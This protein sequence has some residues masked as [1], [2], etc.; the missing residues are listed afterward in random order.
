MSCVGIRVTGR[1]LTLDSWL[2]ESGIP[3][4]EGL[5][6]RMLTKKIR[7]KGTMLGILQVYEDLGEDHHALQVRAD[8]LI[9]EVNRAIHPDNER[10]AYVVAT[11][12][13]ITFNANSDKDVVLIDCG[14]KRSIIK[15]ILQRKFNVV[16]VPPKT[17]SS[18]IMDLDP[19]A[20]ILSN[21]PGDPRMYDEVID[22]TRELINAGVPLLGICLGCQILALSCGAKTYKLKFG[23]RGQ[24]HPCID[25][26]TGRCYITSQ[27]HSYVVDEKTL[28][29]TG[30]R[31]TFINANDKT[32]EGI[33]HESLP[34][35][36]VQFHPEA[37]PGP[38]DTNFY[39]DQFLAEIVQ[40]R[41]RDS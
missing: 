9:K 5:D 18:E 41:M 28:G 6:T 27:N 12:R 29:K 33:E 20:V 19:L 34:I 7:T 38:T 22:T 35:K 31:V 30:L 2:N 26:R 32:I 14:V 21:G 40:R 23:H 25:V 4:I 37:S 1:K 13:I 10:L 3:G 11:D 24:N 8:S 39:F 16:L 17:P 15:N 36:A